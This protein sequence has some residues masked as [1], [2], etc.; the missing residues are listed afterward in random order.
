MKKCVSELLDQNDVRHE[1]KGRA[2]SIY[3]IYKN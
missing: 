1:I 3:S 2:K